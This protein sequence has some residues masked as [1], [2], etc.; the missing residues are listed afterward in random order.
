[1]YEVVV[2]GYPEERTKYG[3]YKN[4]SHAQ[5]KKTHLELLQGNSVVL[6]EVQPITSADVDYD[7]EF[8]I[9]VWA[10]T[11]SESWFREDSW[12]QRYQDAYDH[13]RRS[14][15]ELVERDD[16]EEYSVQIQRRL[17]SGRYCHTTNINHADIERVP[18]DAWTLIEQSES[19][20]QAKRNTDYN[21]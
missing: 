4:K 14:K 12:Q 16:V 7:L 6:H 13:G 9:V 17:P 20:S 1:M 10:S 3:P 11:S 8:R 5:K 18:F 15:E 21:F 2:E 19:E